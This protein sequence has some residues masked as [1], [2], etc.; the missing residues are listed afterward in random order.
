MSW[1][2]IGD[3]FWADPRILRAASLSGA[4]ARTVNELSGFLVRLGSYAAQ[5]ELDYLIPIDA[6]LTIPH[7]ADAERLIRMLIELGLAKEISDGE[8]SKIGVIDDPDLLHMVSKE[9]RLWRNQR[10]RDARNADLVVPVRQRDGDQCRWC[11][12]VVHWPGKPSN[13]KATLDHLV[14]GMAATVDTLVVSCWSCNSARKDDPNWELENELRDKPSTPLYGA[15]TVKYL[16]KY[17]V[18]VSQN[19]GTDK[20]PSADDD[21][22]LNRLN[23]GSLPV[24][25]LVPDPSGA[26]TTASGVDGQAGTVS[27][28]YNRAELDPICE[29]NPGPVETTSGTGD[30]GVPETKVSTEVT[31]TK[32]VLS[33]RV[34][35]ESDRSRLGAGSGR[36]SESSQGDSNV[37]L[38][39]K[40]KRRRRKWR[41]CDDRQCEG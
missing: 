29:S 17:G 26:S 13:R 24:S 22:A 6:A 14:P 12:H 30:F 9:E 20:L 18:V 28:G 8:A 23:A 25:K 11:G 4:D 31:V 3:T 21:S 37:L 7:V 32:P 40:R 35:V 27:G 36:L 2:R 15:H 33:G 34:G 16:A 19:I 38:H 41:G 5:Y 1:L 39:G 10:K